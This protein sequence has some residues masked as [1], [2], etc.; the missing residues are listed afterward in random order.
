ME[1]RAVKS[2]GR[3][4]S[5]AAS[6]H[7]ASKLIVQ[8]L[9]ALQDARIVEALQNVLMPVLATK[10]EPRIK[11]LEEEVA[12]LKGQVEE[13]TKS[14]SSAVQS[15][16]SLNA[17]P[18]KAAPGQTDD[19][20]VSLHRELEEKRRRAANIVVQG[21]APREGTTDAELFSEF[22]EANLSTKPPF[23]R[24]KCVRLGS[25]D[26]GRIRPLRVTFESS[27]GAAD[28]LECANELR[29]KTPTIYI[30]P[31]LTKAEAQVAFEQRERRRAR[32]RNQAGA[33]V[34]DADAPPSANHARV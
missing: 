5:P 12:A 10:Y 15:Q 6:S 29:G 19:T 31:D 22:M 8:L 1:T 28:V 23:K 27:I 11:Q 17:Q 18:R 3:N 7:D 32:H 33:G 34:A 24:D 16:P 30:N 9:T 4:G 13:L 2:A 25:A 26:G 21:L 14:A 20:L